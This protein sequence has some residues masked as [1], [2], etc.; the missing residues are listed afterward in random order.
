[1]RDF[2]LSSGHHLT[3]RDAGG[4]LLVTDA[5][6]KAYLARPELAPPPEACDAERRLHAALLADPRRDVGAG[7][8]AAIEDADARENWQVMIA[9]RDHLLRHRTLE[10]AYLDLVAG[11]AG[12]TPPLFLDQLTHVILRNILDDIDDPF[13]V[14]AAEL[15]FRP[16]RVAL[17]DGALLVAD[18]ETIDSIGAAPVSPLMAALGAPAGAEIDVLSDDNAAG[19]WARSDRFDMALDLTVGRRGLTA[20]ADVVARW[21]RHMLAVEVAVEPLRALHEA[22]FTWYVGLDAE[23]TRIGDA[24]WRGDALDDDAQ[25]R[26]AALLRLTFQESAPADG[27]A[28]YLILAMT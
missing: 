27:D 7:E 4:G 8:I 20:L 5:F 1:M 24:L 3:D 14:R 19:Y 21:T 10:A 12:R 22:P 28:V 6:L 16:Q 9:F 26:V 11:K 13:I 15:F 25:K 17:R 2:W 18:E 23:G